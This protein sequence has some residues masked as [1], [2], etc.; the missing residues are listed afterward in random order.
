MKVVVKLVVRRW[1][2][3]RAQAQPWRNKLTQSESTG[4]ASRFGTVTA[5]RRC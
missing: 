1:R 5:I 2:S 4:S 3:P